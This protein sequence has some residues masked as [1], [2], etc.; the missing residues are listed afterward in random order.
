MRDPQVKLEREKRKEKRVL[1]LT[2]GMRDIIL[3]TT[4][5]NILLFYIHYLCS[6]IDYSTI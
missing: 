2:T 6:S 3:L 5:F 4:A 1:D